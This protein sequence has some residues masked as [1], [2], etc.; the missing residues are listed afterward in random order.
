MN[1]EQQQ[2]F[3][4]MHEPRPQRYLKDEE[5]IKIHR[6]LGRCSEKQLVDLLKFGGCRAD[7]KQIT[8]IMKK[9][10]CQRSVRRIT[11]PVVSR[12]IA[13]FSGEVVAIDTIYPFSDVGADGFFPLWK[14]IR[15]R[16][17]RY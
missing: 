6:Q 16:S 3:P 17:L 11:P 13:R 1:H 9:C 7:S 5:V 10:N 2:V 14:K 15:E 12:W 8:R 4:A